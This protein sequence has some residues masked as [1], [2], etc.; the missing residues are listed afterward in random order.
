MNP[1]RPLSAAL[2]SALLL[3]PPAAL[4]QSRPGAG[5]EAEESLGVIEQGLRRLLEGFL[6][7][8]EPSLNE[9]G[10]RLKG[11]EPVLREWGDLIGDLENYHAPERLPNGDILLRRKFSAQPPPLPNP[12]HLQP[13]PPPGPEPRRPRAPQDEGAIEL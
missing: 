10:E 8:M 9:L 4:A 11:Y 2:L 3:L 7:D 5:P 6:T 13:D 1:P 12:D